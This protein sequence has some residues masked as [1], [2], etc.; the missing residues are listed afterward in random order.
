ME[1]NTDNQTATVT[2]P[3]PSS[4]GGVMDV[5][6]PKNTPTASS[7]EPSGDGEAIKVSVE[8][9]STPAIVEAET[10][11][12]TEPNT[13]DSSEVTP[14][15]DVVGETPP[16]SPPNDNPLAANPL[17]P[18]KKSGAP[19]A[20]IIVAIIIALALAGVTVFAFTRGSK[21]KTTTSA[22]TTSTAATQAAVKVTGTDVDKTSQGLDDTLKKADDTK[23][24][25][26]TELT[27]Q[28]LG[29]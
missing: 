29:L 4:T 3:T 24:F 16:V 1:E 15:L 20:A 11:L 22:P 21:K 14:T 8:T 6:A 17:P 2:A 10:S 26:S 25:S 13:K 12:T 28:S 18:A 9:S 19:K 5:Q 7:T 27:D 23:D